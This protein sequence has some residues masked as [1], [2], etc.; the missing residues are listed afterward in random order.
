VTDRAREFSYWP[1]FVAP[2][3]EVVT[4]AGRRYSSGPAV[5]AA[6]EGKFNLVRVAHAGF[7]S[8]PRPASQSSGYW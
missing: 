5:G 3:G 2:A 7:H 4:P 6:A 1:P 8:S